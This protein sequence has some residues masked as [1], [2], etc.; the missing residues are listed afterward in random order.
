MTTDD[1]P[2]LG[3]DERDRRWDALRSIM[4]GSDLDAVLVSGAGRDRWDR[5]LTG[6][7]L[8]GFAFLARTGQAV[9]LLGKFP[10]ER[11][12]A[13]GKQIPRWV[14]DFRV[15]KLP[16]L[17]AALLGERQLEGAR[18][19]VVGLS[20]R[21][22]GS[23][24][25]TISFSLWSEVLAAC[26]GVEFVDIAEPFERL[27]LVK[28]EDER[29]MVRHAA[30]IGEAAC[31][32]FVD[33]CR[34]RVPE[35][36]PVAAAIAATVSRGGWLM[37]PT[38]IARSGPGS[39]AWSPAE[40]THRGGGSRIL[41]QGDLVAAELFSC[42]GGYETQQQIHVSIG[43]PS[44]DVRRLTDVVRAAQTVAL[45]L[46]R[47]GV[48]FSEV[49][50]QVRGVVLDAGY[51]ST[52]PVL[53]TVSPVMFNDGTHENMRADPFLTDLP[54]FPDPV[55]PDGDFVIE[56]GVAFAVQPNA[57]HGGDRICLG[58]TVLINDDGVEELNSIP[59]RLQVV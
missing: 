1:A 46:L 48:L 53:Q 49:T 8:G 47:P 54:R 19:G 15:G 23:H 31:Q 24:Q 55:P 56:A 4:S 34:I 26:P 12:D 22:I 33:A 36:F 58:G 32:A 42:Y 35:S 14:D 28:S 16:G 9:Q 50:A 17:L 2:L 29:R 45:E 10:L 30:S 39:F 25:G 59:T 41:E 5:Y 6:E 40:W 43:E 52:G 37:D 57:I 13:T 21:S 20:S 7:A 18:I 3:V 38:I 11:F 44:A 51:W 27:A